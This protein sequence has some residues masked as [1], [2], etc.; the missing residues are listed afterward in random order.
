MNGRCGSRFS[1][2]AL[3]QTKQGPKSIVALRIAMLSER[4]SRTS[5]SEIWDA[6]VGGT[7]AVGHEFK[8]AR[9]AN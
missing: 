9:L 6:A 1:L 2:T 4:S 3:S 5:G 8:Y 7:K